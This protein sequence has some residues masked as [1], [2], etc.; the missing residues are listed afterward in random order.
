MF[1]LKKSQQSKQLQEVGSLYPVLHVADS[2]K[3]YQHELVEKEVSSLGELS[4]VRSSFAGVLEEGDRFQAQ[5]QDLGE[6]FSNINETAEQFGQVRGEIGQAVSEAR[7]QM[8]ALGQISMQVQQSF[9]TMAECLSRSRP[10]F[11]PSTPQ[12]KQPERVLRG[13]ASRW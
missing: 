13:R 9:D 12:L 11:W 2:L 10:T 1:F 8:A 7:G 5:L 3:Q 6:S 4:R